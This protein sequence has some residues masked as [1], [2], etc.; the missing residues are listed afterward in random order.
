MEEQ[1]HQQQH[2]IAVH[3]RKVWRVVATARVEP[4][5]EERFIQA[6]ENQCIKSN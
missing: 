6:S 4:T 3:E 5:Q 2:Q 1:V